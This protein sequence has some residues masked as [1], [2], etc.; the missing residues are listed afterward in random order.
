M[1][2]KCSCNNCGVHIEFEADGFQ[3]E[4]R[5][6]CPHCHMETILFIPPASAL[7]K[8]KNMTAWLVVGA[9]M[10]TTI[11]AGLLLKNPPKQP[12][13]VNE[14]PAAISQE[15]AKTEIT[16][17]LPKQSNLKPVVGAFGWTLG[18]QLPNRLRP[19]VQGTDY[20]SFL[21]FT[22]ETEWPPFNN[23]T[24]DLTPDGRIC[25]IHA[26]A[27]FPSRFQENFYDATERVIS[28]LTEK[29]GLRRHVPLELRVLGDDAYEFGTVDQTAN[30]LIFQTGDNKQ[31]W[32]E[33][34][35][36][37]LK[38]LADNAHAAARTKDEDKKKAALSKG[39]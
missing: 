34:Y 28:V 17:S 5:A 39:L 15:Q 6:E 4:T 16:P 19:Q 18:N 13:T 2:A 12:N 21:V 29:Y 7:Q 33:Y 35:D 26:T 30:L 37:N 20:P 3:P 38:N 23:F 1:I 24:L 8:Q 9:V 31:L 11:I 14:K 22:P 27:V 32:L 25:S 36:K 10:L